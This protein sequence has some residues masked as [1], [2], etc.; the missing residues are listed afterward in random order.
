MPSDGILI[1]ID[2]LT[3][4]T[5]RSGS[6]TWQ[7]SGKAKVHILKGLADQQLVAGDELSF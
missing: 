6:T 2:E 4:L 5:K 3:A 1:G 7:V